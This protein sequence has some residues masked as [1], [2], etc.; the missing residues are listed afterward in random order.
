MRLKGRRTKEKSPNSLE[1]GLT[2]NSEGQQVAI[3]FD[4]FSRPTFDNHLISPVRE[5]F[6]DLI[7]KQQPVPMALF[8][9]IAEALKESFVL[10]RICV[11]I[12]LDTGIL[13]AP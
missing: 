11:V 7:T 9:I 5:L 12:D 3:D 13:H 8:F 1:M 2:V 4:L 10:C 6:N